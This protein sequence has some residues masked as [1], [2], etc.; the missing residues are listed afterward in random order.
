MFRLAILLGIF[1]WYSRER[2]LQICSAGR[3]NILSTLTSWASS[4]RDSQKWTKITKLNILNECT[5]RCSKVRSAISAVS[6][7]ILATK[8]QHFNVLTSSKFKLVPC[9]NFLSFF[10]NVCI[11]FGRN[12]RRF[13]EFRERNIPSQNIIKF[14]RR[15]I[16]MLQRKFN[17]FHNIDAI[18]SH[19]FWKGPA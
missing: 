19:K 13:V 7:P 10:K 8:A 4:S 11:I 16:K 9:H 3:A 6:T 18:E 5:Y 14:T 17:N 15:A 12:Q 2:T 1:R